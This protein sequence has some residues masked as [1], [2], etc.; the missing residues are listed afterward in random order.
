MYHKNYYKFPIK[1]TS[2][3]DDYKYRDG[4]TPWWWWCIW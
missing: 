3:L 2:Y 4:A 1:G